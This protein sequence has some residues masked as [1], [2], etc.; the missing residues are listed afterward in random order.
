MILSKSLEQQ[1][2]TSE[3]LGVISRSPREL[4]PVFNSML[5]NATR[6][7]G[8]KFGVLFLT[9]GDGFRSVATHGLPPAHARGASP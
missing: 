1:T 6:I 2:A 5:V 4:S 7:C 3:V 8:A 9:E